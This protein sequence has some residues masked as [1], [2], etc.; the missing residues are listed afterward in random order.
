MFGIDTPHLTPLQ[1]RQMSGRAGRRGY[2]PAG[3][4]IFMALPTR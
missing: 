3:N 1:Y 2:D 4:V